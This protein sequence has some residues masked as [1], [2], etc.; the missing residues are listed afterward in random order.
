MLNTE[1]NFKKKQKKNI[2]NN[3]NN[4]KTTHLVMNLISTPTTNRCLAENSLVAKLRGF[5]AG[6]LAVLT[7][8]MSR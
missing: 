1:E 4:N 3:N 6:I 8:P 5:S 7:Q 2:K